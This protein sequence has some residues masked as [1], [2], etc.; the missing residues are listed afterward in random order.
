MAFD[1]ETRGLDWFDPSKAAFLA[2]W[3]D[4]DGEYVADLSDPAQSATFLSA[5]AA[6]DVLVAHNLSFDTHMVREATGLDIT[7]LGKQLE[8]TDLMS[9][10]LFP[11]GANK[12]AFGSHKLKNLA[13]VWLRADAKVAEDEIEALAK[14]IGTDLKGGDGA[15][16][17]VWRAYPDAMEYYAKQDARYTY[18]LYTKF[19]GEFD[20][21]SARCYGLEQGVA[22]IL[23]R[24]EQKGI[25]LDQD[26]VARLRKHYQSRQRELYEELEPIFGPDAL[27]GKGSEEALLNALAELGVP[28][29]R[30]TK[31]TGKLQ[32]NKFALQEFEKDFPALKHLKE[33]RV[34]SKFLSTYLDPMV[35]REQIHTSFYQCEAWTGRMSSRRPN[36]QNVPKRAGKEIREVFIPREGHVFV[37]SDYESIEVRLLAYYLGGSEFRELVLE[38]DPHAWMASNIWGGAAEDYA[39]DGPNDKRRSLAKN[40][41]FA[42]TYGA[43]APRVQD[44]LQ[45][46]DM[47]ASVEAAKSL[48]SAIK[49]NLPG[50]PRL[51][52]R[53]RDKI[54]AHGYVQT[55][56]GRKQLVS[57]DKSYV[58][59]N[60]L[61]QGSAADILKQGLINVAAAVEEFNATPLLV[62]HDEVVTEAPA[63]YGDAVLAAQNA[64]MIA[65]YDLDPALSVSGSV[66]TTSYADA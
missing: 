31:K 25:R 57:P 6:A 4:A 60:A 22:P 20:E 33:Y 37:V 19:S 39:K 18:D 17:D 44:M 29:Y 7:G 30:K 3:A 2:T 52:K 47:P 64:A 23:I 40:I 1:T 48:I 9:R 21:K 50:Y 36:M 59:L 63:E 24:A 66:V 56:F 54:Q 16:Y 42:I 51:N 65:A 11:E 58:G 35:G 41:L 43:G 28:L 32:T 15:Y 12:G 27:G 55:L 8:D 13:T 46:A 34:V 26:A 53:I 38:R 10:V 49:T 5:L 62:V 61:I 14:S 45:D